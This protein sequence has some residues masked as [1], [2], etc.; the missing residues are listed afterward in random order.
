[1]RIRMA[2][3]GRVF[4]GT[5]VQIVEA[6]RSVAFAPSDVSLDGYIDWAVEQAASMNDVVLVV[7]GE[8]VQERAQSFVKALVGAGWAVWL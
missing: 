2:V 8:S 6:M 7:Q 3:D 1:M 5:A 4:E